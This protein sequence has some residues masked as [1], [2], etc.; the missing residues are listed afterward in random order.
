[1]IINVRLNVFFN[2]GDN[3]MLTYVLPIV[4]EVNSP[5]IFFGISLKD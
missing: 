4:R 3:C 2:K 1:M 5:L